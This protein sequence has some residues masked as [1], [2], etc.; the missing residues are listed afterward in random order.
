METLRKYLNS[1]PRQ[2][3]R[4]YAIRCGTTVNYLRNA[5]S[6]K[7]RFD[8]ALCLRLEKESGGKVKKHELRP[9]IWPEL[10]GRK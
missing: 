2:D 10:C 5:I 7:K 9:D 8:G 4:D 1:L 6:N 3:Q